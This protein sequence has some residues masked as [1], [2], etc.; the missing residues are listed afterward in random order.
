M[1]QTAAQTGK[2]MRLIVAA[3]FVG[4]GIPAFSQNEMP[5]SNRPQDSGADFVGAVGC[6]SSLCHG[7]AGPNRGSYTT[8]KAKDIHHTSWETLGTNRSDAMAKAIGGE[9]A[10]KTWR[11]T[12]CHM[13]M[14][15]VPPSRM[16]ADVDPKDGVS[17]ETCHGP[18]S[19]W[20][21]THTRLDL[22]HAQRLSIGMKDLES[23]YV[24]A[25]TCIAC[26]QNVDPGLLGA[27][28]PDLFFELDG[29]SEREPEHWLD[30]GDW[31]GPK[32]WFTGQAAA[33]REVS[34]GLSKQGSPSTDY[35]GQ[36]YALM[37]VLETA[38]NAHGN[39][40]GIGANPPE[41][42][43]EAARQIQGNADNLARAAATA[44][45]DALST[46]R[47]LDALAGTSATFIANA[48]TEKPKSEILRKKAHR[49][50]LALDRL[51]AALNTNK[52]FDAAKSLLPELLKI[53]TT[54]P[55]FDG[56]RF[57]GKLSEFKAALGL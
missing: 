26:H 24:R 33:L 5:V 9:S 35:I 36:W 37:W 32:A 3:L 6:S 22:T 14:A 53:A 20:I 1:K 38:G 44:S 31:F 28:H 46:R 47:A 4:C 15:T 17:C 12:E 13:P 50:T 10:L 55:D 30:K 45:W 23:L 56:E 48:T 52:Q 51:V 57:A 2:V 34:W 54:Y 39:L 19:E 18:A 41:F 43:P 7:G 42:S 21:R 25:N 27:G 49:L 8:W 11:C 16:S 29:Q 40:G